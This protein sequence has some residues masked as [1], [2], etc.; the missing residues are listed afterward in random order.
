MRRLSSSTAMVCTFLCQAFR[1]AIETAFSKLIWLGCGATRF[2]K[3]L[4][5]WLAKP[6][7]QSLRG[8]RFIALVEQC[9]F[10][11]T[12][13]ARDNDNIQIAQGRFEAID[14]KTAERFIATLYQRDVNSALSASFVSF[15]IVARLESRK[16]LRLVLAQMPESSWRVVQP[17]Y[18]P[19]RV[20]GREL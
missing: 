1:K 17:W 5:R 18:H 19:R 9:C 14:E 11:D 2:P 15:A 16:V 12:R 10:G 6:S 7:G 3:A 20:R 4:P 13:P 8:A